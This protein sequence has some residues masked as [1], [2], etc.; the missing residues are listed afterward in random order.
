MDP[1]GQGK[2]K[3]GSQGRGICTLGA[4]VC[5]DMTGRQIENRDPANRGGG[6]DGRRRLLFRIQCIDGDFVEERWDGNAIGDVCFRRCFEPAILVV[7]G[8]AQFVEL[9]GG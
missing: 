1:E 3:Q 8:F 4:R 2:T 6:T 9:F 7:P 5:G